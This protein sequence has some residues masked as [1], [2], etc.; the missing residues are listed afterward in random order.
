MLIQNSKGTEEFFGGQKKKVRVRDFFL[1]KLKLSLS[2]PLDLGV[3][4]LVLRG[5][6]PVQALRVDTG[7]RIPGD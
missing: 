3:C 7:Q 1:V 6:R 5:R 2:H 4:T